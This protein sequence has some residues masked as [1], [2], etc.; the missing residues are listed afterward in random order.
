M[1]AWES[2]RTC[3]ATEPSPRG[4][5]S[6]VT[7]PPTK[8]EPGGLS[9]T[10]IDVSGRTSGFIHMRVCPKDFNNI[11]REFQFLMKQAH[12]RGNLTK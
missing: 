8:Q 3:Q 9:P 7:I 12:V 4:L 2:E 11:F 1:Q 10:S 5:R 6:I